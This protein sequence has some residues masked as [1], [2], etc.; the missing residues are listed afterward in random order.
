MADQFDKKTSELYSTNEWNGALGIH[1]D[2]RYYTNAGVSS[3][4][5]DVLFLSE[6]DEESLQAIPDYI[7]SDT[8][9]KSID[10]SIFSCMVF[11]KNSKYLPEEVKFSS[12][13]GAI[14]E[15]DREGAELKN[16]EKFDI[17]S[18]DG[19]PLYLPE[20]LEVCSKNKFEQLA[21]ALD[22]I[23]RDICND[24]GF[25]SLDWFRFRILY[26]YFREYPLPS[27]NAYLIG[28][29]YKELILKSRFEGDLTHYYTNLDEAQKRRAIG[30][31]ATKEKASKLRDYCVEEFVN[32]AE[33][34]GPRF[35]MAP[36]EV[37]AEE[38]RKAVLSKRKDDYSR[39]N[40]PYRVEWFLRNIIEDRKFELL[41]GLEK[42]NSKRLKPL[43]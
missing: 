18:V 28:E 27:T 40:K 30:T 5:S 17:E 25:L 7:L 29:L 10:G 37:Q 12:K 4:V 36:P 16:W 2:A 20:D 34:F 43:P 15:G 39:A 13:L 1:R 6:V 32:L 21:F 3:W 14:E 35:L 24:G 33:Q 31:A 23:V 41:E 9:E 8:L 22:L 11:A 19:N 38:L 26:E 42:N